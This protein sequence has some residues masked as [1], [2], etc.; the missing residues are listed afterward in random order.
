VYPPVEKYLILVHGLSRPENSAW[1]AR[2]F[3]SDSERQQPF[4]HESGRNSTGD[5]ACVGTIP[6]SAFLRRGRIIIPDADESELSFVDLECLAKVVGVIDSATEGVRIR[7][8]QFGHSEEVIATLS[9]LIGLTCNQTGNDMSGFSNAICLLG[10]VNLSSPSDIAKLVIAESIAGQDKAIQASDISSFS[11]I[12]P[13]DTK[14][15]D[16]AVLHFHSE[17]GRLFPEYFNQNSYAIGLMQK[18]IRQ[19]ILEG[20]RVQWEARRSEFVVAMVNQLKLI[21]KQVTENTTKAA[22]DIIRDLSSLPLSFNFTLD[23]LYANTIEP[24]FANLTILAQ[25]IHPDCPEIIPDEMGQAFQRIADILKQWK[26]RQIVR[27]I[28]E[29]DPAESF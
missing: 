7:I 9:A 28:P 13:K 15:A 27:S 5:L 3:G 11:F 19:Q 23:V 4:D 10:K 26:R 6:L 2:I 18:G 16:D 1:R 21:G 22:S 12:L 25:T 14:S 20:Y 24:A 8:E 17:C 29:H